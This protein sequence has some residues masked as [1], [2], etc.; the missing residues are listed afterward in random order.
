MKK[1][2]K[3]KS[4]QTQASATQ[5]IVGLITTLVERLVSLEA[6]MD[7]VL[8]R[9]QARPAEPP[10]QHHLPP[11]LPHAMP[12][13]TRQMYTAICA[14][15]RK[16]CEVPFKPSAGRSVYC[17]GCYSARRN[18]GSSLPRADMRPKE[19]Q[20]MHARHPEKPQVAKPAASAGK[21]KPAAKKANKA[22]K[23]A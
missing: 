20:P 18:N 8:S 15:C 3:T 13:N 1:S 7:T 22:K 5:D 9:I 23:K 17:K 12:R 19:T 14:D 2:S 21:K 16:N 10:R 6:K 11:P 4:S